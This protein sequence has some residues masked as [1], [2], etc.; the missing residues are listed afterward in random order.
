VGSKNRTASNYIAR[1]A[2]KMVKNPIN[3]QKT[4]L[5]EGIGTT[6]GKK[7]HRG[8]SRGC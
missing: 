5:M 2:D 4:F 7:T 6:G 8:G 1:K 3:N